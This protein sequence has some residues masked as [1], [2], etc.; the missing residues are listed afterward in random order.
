MRKSID[1]LATLVAESWADAR[2]RTAVFVGFNKGRD[3]IRL[4]W[5][6]RQGFWM[7]YKRLERGR[8]RLPALTQMTVADL[9]L[10]LEGLEPARRQPS[11][12]REWLHT[13]HPRLLPQSPLAKACQYALHQWGSA[14]ALSPGWALAP[15]QQ[16]RGKGHAAGGHGPE[17]LLLRRIDPQRGSHRHAPV[18]AALG[19]P[20]WPQPPRLPQGHSDPHALGQGGRYPRFAPAPLE[21]RLN[22]LNA[23]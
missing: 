6:D 3:K 8:F 14:H 21:T 19:H 4:L 2:L 5:W 10:M 23:R 9:W 18:A 12:S 7:A 22:P 16:R 15:V 13:H 20:L 11:L 17:E 1:G